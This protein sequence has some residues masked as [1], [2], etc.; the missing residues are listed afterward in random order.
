VSLPCP[1]PFSEAGR[2]G[3]SAAHG[4]H[5]QRGLPGD[6]WMKGMIAWEPRTLPG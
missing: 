2:R 5:T 4:S 3:L 6:C 1:H